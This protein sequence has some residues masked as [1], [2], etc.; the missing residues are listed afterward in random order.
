M[1]HQTFVVADPREFDGDPFDVAERAVLQA[2]AVARVLKQALD[3]ARLMARNAE[4]ERQ[5]M[6]GGDPDPLA[7]EQ[8]AQGKRLRL[9]Q[10]QA[11]AAEKQLTVLARAAGYNPK[12]PIGRPE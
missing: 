3:G 2:G 9:L 4:M 7:F 1:T 6:G 8:G 5:L 11:G 12:R 10:E